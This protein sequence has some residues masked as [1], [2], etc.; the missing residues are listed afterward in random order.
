LT[1]VYV[2]WGSEAQI[3]RLG[4]FDDRFLIR[5]GAIVECHLSPQRLEQMARDLNVLKP[6]EVLR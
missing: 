5:E 4:E 3:L 6:W 2:L 1:H